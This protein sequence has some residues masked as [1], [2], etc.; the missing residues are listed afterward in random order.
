MATGAWF[1]SAALFFLGYAASSA[2]SAEKSTPFPSLRLVEQTL[3][4]T[5]KLDFSGHEQAYQAAT[6]WNGERLYASRNNLRAPHLACVEHGHGREAAFRFSEVLSPESVRPVSHSREH[7]VCYMVTASQSEVAALIMSSEKA[8]LALS[9]VGPFP[10][11]LKLAPGLLDHGGSSRRRSSTG[12]SSSRVGY[13]ETSNAALGRLA[14]S[15]GS[16]MSM[17]NVKGLTVELSPGTLPA[18]S[19][20]SDTFIG[21]LLE[22]LMSESIDLHENNFWSDPAMSEGQHL[23]VPEGGLRGREWSRAAT[24]VH[25]LSDAAEATPGDICSWDNV[26]VHHAG[27]DVLLVS[28]TSI[29][30]LVRSF[31]VAIVG[32]SCK[33]STST[34]SVVYA[35]SGFVCHVCQLPFWEIHEIGYTHGV[36]EQNRVQYQNFR[37]GAR[38]RT[39]AKRLQFAFWRLQPTR[40]VCGQHA[41]PFFHHTLKTR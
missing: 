10:S 34:F 20:E 14:T 3:L 37:T 32:V 11:V 16:L 27:D 28:G 41:K 33:K 21:D 35:V 24:V 40:A 6:R 1:P 30:C 15:H 39:P 7:G 26:D 19:F 8:G 29:D 4:T 5:A 9:S 25:E 23:A 36:F 13:A 22:G 12:D 18:R 38:Q 2:S 31:L 17:D